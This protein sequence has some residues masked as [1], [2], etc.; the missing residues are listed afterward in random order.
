MKKSVPQKKT[1]STEHHEDHAVDLSELRIAIADL[2][3]TVVAGAIS[4]PE[5]LKRA[6]PFLLRG[7]AENDTH[8]A[9]LADPL[10]EAAI[11]IHKTVEEGS[12]SS[13]S[14]ASALLLLPLLGPIISALVVNDATALAEYLRAVKRAQRRLVD[15]RG[16]ERRRREGGP[17]VVDMLGWLKSAVAK[18]DAGMTS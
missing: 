10:I 7:G 4:N 15:R 6:A 3:K 14:E 18:V 1:K 12:A 8:H 17:N 11:A 16:E 5:E 13:L 9:H 2:R